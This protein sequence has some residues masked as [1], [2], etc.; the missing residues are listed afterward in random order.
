MLKI[1]DFWGMG[2]AVKTYLQ[3]CGFGVASCEGFVIA[4][5]D[6]EIWRF[7]VV[8]GGG[9]KETVDILAKC[10]KRSVLAIAPLVADELRRRGY[11]SYTGAVLGLHV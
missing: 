3:K 10:L 1:K 9:E 5:D 11:S 7:D 4:D 8:M 6:A 2:V